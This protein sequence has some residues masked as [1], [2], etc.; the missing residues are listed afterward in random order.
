M[1]TDLVVVLM[2]T[3]PFRLG[4]YRSQLQTWKIPAKRVT[5]LEEMLDGSSWMI[6]PM[7]PE[8][9]DRRGSLYFS[10]KCS[11]VA[12]RQHPNT[13][14]DRVEVLFAVSQETIDGCVRQYP[15]LPAPETS[16][17]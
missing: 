7:L 14:E 11:G 15:E 13:G 8:G 16:Y 2:T 17:I 12:I 3:K 4:Q 6:D 9:I 5:S 1:K 10:G